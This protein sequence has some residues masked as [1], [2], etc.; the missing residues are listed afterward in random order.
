[1]TIARW[2]AGIDVT[3][4]QGDVLAAAWLIA[5]FGADRAAGVSLRDV[6]DGD[7]TE[8]EQVL[9]SAETAAITDRLLELSQREAIRDCLMRYC[10]GS[11]RC[12]AAL[13]RSAF[14]PDATDS[15]A[16]PGRAPINAYVFIDKILPK[17]RAMD[18]TMHMLG[19]ILI[20]LRGAAAAVESYFHAYHRLRESAGT[21]R[22]V[23]TAGRYLDRFERR[24]DEWRIAERV[25]VVD[26]FREFDDSADWARGVFGGPCVM[27][28]KKPEDVS[29]TFFG[30]VFGLGR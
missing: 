28:Q 2:R 17:L 3:A 21:A 7:A 27:G 22:D 1:M 5:A 14:W 15:H 18:Q 26:W 11:D 9:M 29:Y 19:N 6:V 8:W 24:G 25:V 10:R 20:E 16:M 13:L 4:A 23:V 12:D 30:E